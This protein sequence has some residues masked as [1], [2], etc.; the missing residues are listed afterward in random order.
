M[1]DAQPTAGPGESAGQSL[2]TLVLPADFGDLEFRVTQD[3][4]EAFLVNRPSSDPLPEARLRE[5]LDRAG[6][7]HG[8]DDGILARISGGG[9]AEALPR[10]ARGTAAEPGQDGR[11]RFQV[12]AVPRPCR[13][14]DD[15][16]I[17]VEGWKGPERVRAGE[18]IAE[19]VRPTRGRPGTTV[20]GDPIPSEDGREAIPSPGPNI[21][22]EDRAEGIRYYAETEGVPHFGRNRL[23]VHRRHRVSGDAAFRRGNHDFEGDVEIVGSVMPGFRL[24]A[25]GSVTVSGGVELGALVEADGDV[26]VGRGIHGHTTVLRAGGSLMV[27]FVRGA[28]VEVGGD[29]E[30]GGYV[31]GGNLS[32]AGR[33]R[34]HGRGRL[35]RGTGAVA[36]GDLTAGEAVWIDS[37]GSAFGSRTQLTAGVDPGELKRVRSIQ[38]GVAFC[39]GNIVRILRTLGV[40]DPT[41]ES[42]DRALAEASPERRVIVAGLIAKVRQLAGQRRRFLDEADRIR[43]GRSERVGQ[44]RIRVD[45]MLYTGVR[46]QIGETGIPILEA[47]NAVEYRLDPAGR[48]LVPKAVLESIV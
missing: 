12:E 21:V 4:M 34:V 19:Y 39:D 10:I 9:V 27:G 8:R 22:V 15:G 18:L 40:T 3:L 31:H 24:K 33:I 20:F 2:T 37:A 48:T 41:A 44:S 28:T 23:S 42:L 26:A 14:L 1:S 11:I 43:R 6:I 16:M 5:A 36:A 7:V 32:A 47:L 29:A 38:T 35:K 46:L 45:G 13:I 25:S 30:V 17:D